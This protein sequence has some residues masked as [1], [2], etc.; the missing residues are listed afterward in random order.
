MLADIKR[1]LLT[2]NDVHGEIGY[3]FQSPTKT[4]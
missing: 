3:E 2:F 1:I 4:R